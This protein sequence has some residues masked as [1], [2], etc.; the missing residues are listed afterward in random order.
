MFNGRIRK[1]R[2][3]LPERGARCV[4]YSPVDVGH[5]AVAQT[6]L[7]HLSQIAYGLQLLSISHEIR[8]PPRTRITC[9]GVGR[10]GGAIGLDRK[11]TE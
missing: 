11:S 10:C 3:L 6:S 4:I 2:W 5:C 9:G 7:P 1:V 8:P